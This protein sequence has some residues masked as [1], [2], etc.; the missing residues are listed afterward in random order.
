MVCCAGQTMLGA[1]KSHWV[2]IAVHIVDQFSSTPFCCL[3][4]FLS[5]MMHS[6]VLQILSGLD[7][8]SEPTTFHVKCPRARISGT[9]AHLRKWSAKGW[10]VLGIILLQVFFSVFF[11]F[12]MCFSLESVGCWLSC[13]FVFLSS[14]LLVFL[15]SWLL[16]FLASWL[17][18]FL[19][20]CLLGFL[21]SWLLDFLASWL[22]RLQWFLGLFWL[23]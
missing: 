12:L 18:G 23:H 15:S 16:G 22:C 5:G 7:M 14:W 11:L 19:A 2:R 9:R 21:P 8:N 3:Q 17:L 20:S 6:C 13:L 1:T 10:D 4:A